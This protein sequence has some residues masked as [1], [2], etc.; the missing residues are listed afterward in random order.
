MALT[1][2]RDKAQKPDLRTS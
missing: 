1:I 2:K